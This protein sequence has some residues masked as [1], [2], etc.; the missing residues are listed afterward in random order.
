[1][2]SEVQR[3]IRESEVLEFP[4]FGN[5]RELLFVQVLKIDTG[6]AKNNTVQNDCTSQPNDDAS[7]P[8]DAERHQDACMVL[9]TPTRSRWRRRS[10][11]T[12]Q[13]HAVLMF[14][15]GES[16][17]QH[18]RCHLSDTH[19]VQ[20]EESILHALTYEVMLDVDVFGA[21]GIRKAE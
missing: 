2:Q 17:G 13:A 8:N 5:V 16:F 6:E 4:N 11:H 3:K 18:V 21:S 7:H 1:M 12:N 9:N 15:A 14:V 10:V 19:E 20:S